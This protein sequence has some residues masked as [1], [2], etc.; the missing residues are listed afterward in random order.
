MCFPNW[1]M[2]LMAAVLGVLMMLCYSF[3]NVTCYRV[4]AFL[5]SSHASTFRPFVF[6]FVIT[7][8]SASESKSDGVHIT[9]DP[10]YYRSAADRGEPEGQFQYG[11]CLFNGRDIPVNQAEAASYFK[12]SAEQGYRDAQYW[13]GHCLSKGHGVTQNISRAL[14]YFQLSADQQY[15]DAQYQLGLAHLN[16]LFTPVNREEAIRYF[17][18]AAKQGHNDAKINFAVCI[19]EAPTNDSNINL[20]GMWDL[21]ELADAG[22]LSA[23]L[24]YANALANGTIVSQDLADAAKYIKKAADLGHPQSQYNFGLCLRD[25]RGVTADHNASAEYIKLAADNGFAPAQNEYGLLLNK[26]HANEILAQNY[27]K[28]SADQGYADG[29]YNYG[30]CISKS[31]PISS[32]RYYALAADQGH[33][34][35]QNAYGLALLKHRFVEPSLDAA[36]NLFRLA[37]AQNHANA[38]TNLAVCLRAT[39]MAAADE[40]LAKAANLGDADGEY[41]FGM[42]LFDLG[43]PEL[44]AEWFLKSANQGNSAG[45]AYYAFCLIMRLGCERDQVLAREYFRKSADLKHPAGT[46]GYGLCLLMGIGGPRHKVRGVEL[47]RIAADD[48]YCHAQ[49]DYAMC[50]KHNIGVRK[51]VAKAAEYAEMALEQGL[52]NE[53][54]L[55]GKNILY[56][57]VMS[58]SKFQ[59]K[60]EVDINM[61]E[62]L[63]FWRLAAQSG[64]LE[65]EYKLGFS[66]IEQKKV[67]EGCKCVEVAARGGH[68]QAQKVLVTKCSATREDE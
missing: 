42:R 61:T 54:H 3:E 64:F 9:H 66:L 50:L 45:C 67:L 7:T 24:L 4:M 2:A 20:I 33:A 56:G 38:M 6:A 36:M 11:L 25:G 59:A 16:G 23:M 43:E 5:G 14:Y 35:G 62:A 57:C 49:S 52:K 12:L 22:Q 47:I 34:G 53:L 30:L 13:Y 10:S 8:T 1:K 51:D 21:Q 68:A 18:L 58:D 60:L 44:A 29:Q 32:V 39:D 55:L 17:Q 41:W 48:G 28:L 19:L 65:A 26:A 15:P 63:K 46:H 40:L 37:A 27:F 31:D